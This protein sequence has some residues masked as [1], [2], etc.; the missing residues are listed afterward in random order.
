MAPTSAFLLAAKWLVNRLMTPVRPSALPNC[1]HHHSRIISPIAALIHP[2]QHMS[3]PAHQA[4]LRAGI[5]LF[6]IQGYFDNI[7]HDRLTQ[8]VADLGFASELVSWSKSFLNKCTVKLRFNG[9]T[10]DPFDFPVGTLQGSPV[11]SVL[12]TI[13]TSPL[14]HKM[15]EW[16]NSSLG[17]YIDNGVCVQENLGRS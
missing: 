5:L 8:L 7:N 2:P 11:S 17:I 16:T 3:P 13:Y 12:S 15:K 9:K 6:D 14:L 1:V 10:S 4:G